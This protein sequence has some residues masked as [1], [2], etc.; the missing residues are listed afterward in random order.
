MQAITSL[1]TTCG[2]DTISIGDQVWVNNLAPMAGRFRTVD[3]MPAE[4]IGFLRDGQEWLVTVRQKGTLNL[5]ITGEAWVH[6]FPAR[7][8]SPAF[9]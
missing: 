2:E 5:P 6:H 4:V 1:P 9:G 3:C 8:I 7:Q